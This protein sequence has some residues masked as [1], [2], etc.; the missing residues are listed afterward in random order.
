[1][2]IAAFMVGAIIGASILF[3]ILVLVGL[4]GD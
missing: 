3:A 2:C 4:S 1:M